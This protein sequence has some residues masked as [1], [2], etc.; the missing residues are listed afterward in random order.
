MSQLKKALEEKDAEAQKI[1]GEI[2]PQIDRI[3][4]EAVEEVKEYLRG[5][6]EIYERALKGGNGNGTM[7]KEKP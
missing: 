6:L 2:I 4:E 7:K 1:I 5:K 3:P